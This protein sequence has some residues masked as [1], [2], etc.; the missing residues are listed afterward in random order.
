MGLYSL[1]KENTIITLLERSLESQSIAIDSRKY[2]TACDYP[3]PCNGSPLP[4]MYF[5]KH[6]IWSFWPI[7]FLYLVYQRE[8]GKL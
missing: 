7:C 2:K 6:Y 4:K 3:W 8:N 5:F 1:R